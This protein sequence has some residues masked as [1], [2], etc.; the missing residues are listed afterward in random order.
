MIHT[1][2]TNVYWPGRTNYH[3]LHRFLSRQD[4]FLQLLKRSWKLVETGGTHGRN[5]EKRGKHMV[6]P[7]TTIGN[8][9]TC[10]KIWENDRKNSG[11][12]CWKD[13]ASCKN[14]TDWHGA[15]GS[16]WRGFPSEALAHGLSLR[17][18]TVG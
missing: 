4:L 10:R 8:I 12:S 1:N 9:G 13:L 2:Q 16:T 17:C 7:G 18:P 5:M 6:Q 11:N 14:Y 15:F 3:R